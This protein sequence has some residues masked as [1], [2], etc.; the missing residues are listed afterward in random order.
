MEKQKEPQISYLPPFERLE[1]EIE[2]LKISEELQMRIEGFERVG[3]ASEKDLGSV[4]AGLAPREGDYV[5]LRVVS[6]TDENSK[7]IGGKRFVIYQ[8]KPEEPYLFLRK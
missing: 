6:I 5:E 2:I 7:F 1:K 8:K 4:V 3:E